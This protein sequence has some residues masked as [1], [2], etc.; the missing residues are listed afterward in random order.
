[1]VSRPRGS[2]KSE[3]SSIKN[4]EI[5]KN[6]GCCCFGSTG[7]LEKHRRKALRTEISGAFVVE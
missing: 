5:A 1:M 2:E 3:E 6:Y 7:M 4:G